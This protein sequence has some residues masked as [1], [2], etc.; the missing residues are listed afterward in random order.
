MSRRVA[1]MVA[2]GIGVAGLLAASA[3]TA[4]SAADGGPR[5]AAP[6]WHIVESVKTDVSGD[7]TAIAATGKTTA[8]AF[9]GTG[10][11]SP[12]R[13]YQLTAG[14]W[15]RAPF[16]GKLDEQVIA[17]GATS[18]S[19]VWAFTAGFG[20]AKSRVLRWNGVKWSVLKTFADEIGNAVVLAANNVWVFGQQPFT[21]Q[22]ALGVWHYNG[23]TWTQVSKNLQG[24]SVLSATDVWAFSGVDV[25]HWTG[26]KWVATSVKKLLPPVI[27]GPLND[28]QVTG[29]FAYSDS[30]VYALGN[31]VD[32][33]EGGP[34]VVLHY[35]GRTWAKVAQ[36]EYG[37]GPSPQI[38]TDGTGGL[39]LPMQGP[40][41]GLSYLLHYAAGKLTPAALPVGPSKITIT[42]VA[43]IPGTT[44]QLA[45]GSTHGTAG[46]NVVGVV[47]QYS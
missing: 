4:A 41:T 6:R 40:V 46:T 39:W 13:A 43:R 2:A 26:G 36:G 16:V 44:E 42:S 28:P 47:L 25:E 33:D 14:G 32:E 15:R 45:G 30:N 1:W 3:A 23:S 12:P 38:S 11:P 35:N 20:A 5:A 21:D 22:P 34:I 27:P 29:I 31:G 37:F 24:G 7:F 17:A 8:W 9:D 10:N 18:P 19:D